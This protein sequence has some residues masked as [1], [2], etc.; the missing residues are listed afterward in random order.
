MNELQKRLLE[1]YAGGD[2]AWLADRE[3]RSGCIDR[4]C[5]GED[6]REAIDAYL[7]EHG[8]DTLLTFLF[9][10]LGEDGGT[11]KDEYLARLQ[12]AIEDIGVVHTAILAHPN[13]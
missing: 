5:E 11:D 13:G 7:E 8:G 10:E 3:Q 9:R 4:D 12:R 2:Y 6:L 1:T